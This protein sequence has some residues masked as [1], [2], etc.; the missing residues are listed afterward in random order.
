M[1]D[2]TIYHI[3]SYENGIRF[4]TISKFYLLSTMVPVSKTFDKMFHHTSMVNSNITDMGV[5]TL[6]NHEIHNKLVEMSVKR[7][8]KHLRTDRSFMHRPRDEVM[9]ADEIVRRSKT[10]TGRFLVDTTT[11]AENQAFRLRY[12][13]DIVNTYNTICTMLYLNHK[14]GTR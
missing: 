6:S 7:F 9:I 1:L 11:Y 13:R 8:L 14:N 10:E 2:S 3:S 12:N 4:G 5:I